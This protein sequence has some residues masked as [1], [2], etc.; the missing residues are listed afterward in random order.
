MSDLKD[1]W[2]NNTIQFTR[3][4]AE[5]RAAGMSRRMMSL[6]TNFMDL[7]PKDIRDL[8]GRA[9]KA[10]EA[11]KETGFT[12]EILMRW[13]EV[14]SPEERPVTHHTFQ[15][16]EELNAFCLGVNEADGWLSGAEVLEC[17]KHPENY[18]YGEDGC[19]PKCKEEDDG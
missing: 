11:I 14:D 7:K 4:L 18:F 16:L 19:C 6:L 13:G 3:L 10:W 15:S 8:L 12:H 17:Q 1:L 5:I 2:P 9:E